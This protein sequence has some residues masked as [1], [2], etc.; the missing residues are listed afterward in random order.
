MK[1]NDK[2]SHSDTVSQWANDVDA[3]ERTIR[4]LYRHPGG[5]AGWRRTNAVTVRLA[6]VDAGIL[7]YTLA[8]HYANE[9]AI[10]GRWAARGAAHLSAV[11]TPGF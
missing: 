2:I 6:H 11:C 4:Q 8:A 5:N 7:C 1:P 3:H 9:P 10:A